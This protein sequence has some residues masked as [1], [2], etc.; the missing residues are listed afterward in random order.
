MFACRDYIFFGSNS[1]LL[2][3]MADSHQ[4]CLI[5]LPLTLLLWFLTLVTFKIYAFLYAYFSNSSELMM[6]HL[7]YLKFSSRAR[8]LLFCFQN[9]FSV[10]SSLIFS[11]RNTLNRNV[12]NTNS[13]W[14]SNQHLKNWL[15][16]SRKIQLM[17][18]YKSFS[19]ETNLKQNLNS[20]TFGDCFC[21]LWD[22]LLTTS[23][24]TA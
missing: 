24:F 17:I 3:H 8:K 10:C 11:V 12:Y 15:K 14:Y 23:T 2:V 5:T 7:V 6:W 4:I 19:K 13:Y 9:A 16:I 18:E 20:N 22:F 21:L 1:T